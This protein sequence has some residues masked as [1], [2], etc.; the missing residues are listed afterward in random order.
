MLNHTGTL[1]TVTQLNTTTSIHSHIAH[2]VGVQLDSTAFSRGHT[3]VPVTLPSASAVCSAANV[4]G[5]FSLCTTGV[6][7]TSPSWE[8]R[9][10]D[11][12]SDFD[13]DF[14]DF[15]SDFDTAW[16]L[17]ATLLVSAPTRV[18]LRVCLPRGLNH[19]QQIHMGF[20]FRILR[21]V[22]VLDIIALTYI[23]I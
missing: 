21:R 14:A 10:M 20:V 23:R 7:P 17:R 4:S 6:W 12:V 8:L 16:V 5:P 3:V 18:A 2:S 11:G 15:D 13:S 9:K 1:C 22:C 19:V